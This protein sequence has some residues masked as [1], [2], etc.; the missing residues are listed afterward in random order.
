M[1]LCPGVLS[2][3]WQCPRQKDA[4]PAPHPPSPEPRSPQPAAAAPALLRAGVGPAQHEER[5]GAAGRAGTRS[6]DTRPWGS[7]AVRGSACVHSCTCVY[8]YAH[9]D[10]CVHTRTCLCTAVHVCARVC[11]T[12]KGVLAGT[13]VP[14]RR[15]GGQQRG[16]TAGTELSRTRSTGR[17]CERSNFPAPKCDGSRLEPPASRG[18]IRVT[19]GLHIWK[20]LGPCAFPRD[21][22]GRAGAA[23]APVPAGARTAAGLIDAL[24][25]TESTQMTNDGCR[26]GRRRLCHPPQGLSE[27]MEFITLT[28]FPLSEGQLLAVLLCR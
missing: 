4:L 10:M 7:G 22:P 20:P 16:Q 13:G 3:R 9:L 2:L 24:L 12:A 8:V 5:R 11:A 27:S 15:T 1:S 28:L 23:Q 18:V 14:A 17:C 21:E 19:Q 6:L 26:R 25:T